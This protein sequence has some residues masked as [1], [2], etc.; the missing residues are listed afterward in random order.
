MHPDTTASL[1]PYRTQGNFVAELRISTL[2][3]IGIDDLRAAIA[4]AL[5]GTAPATD[6]RISNTRH[7]DALHRARTAVS[8]ALAGARAYRPA[9]LLAIDLQD[10]VNA[11][12]EITGEDA[13]EA[14]L[15]VV[16]AR[17]CIGK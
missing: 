13:T 6:R 16:F 3:G 11:L 4:Q 9:E 5:R 17:F 15:D 10:A 8:D 14:L 7:L 1:K 2:H 12:A